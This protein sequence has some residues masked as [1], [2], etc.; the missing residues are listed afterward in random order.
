MERWFLSPMI[1]IL[2]P[3]LFQI[4][5]LQ[6]RFLKKMVFQNIDISIVVYHSVFRQHQK[7]SQ[8]KFPLKSPK[9]MTPTYVWQSL[10]QSGCR[11]DCLHQSSLLVHTLIW[12]HLISNSL[13]GFY[14]S[15]LKL[16]SDIVFF[17][18]PCFRAYQ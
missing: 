10:S 12:T 16:F 5:E 15:V 2:K 17:I 3:V 1:L 8:P 11:S 18:I 13:A 14:F 9:I 4:R 7:H 6:L